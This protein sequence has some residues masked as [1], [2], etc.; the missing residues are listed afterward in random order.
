ML[1]TGDCRLILSELAKQGGKPALLRR[2]TTA[3]RFGDSY[4]TMGRLRDMLF[5]DGL[6][7]PFSATVSYDGGCGF[8]LYSTFS[9]NSKG[10]CDGCLHGA[11]ITKALWYLEFLFRIYVER[12]NLFK[13]SA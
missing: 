7:A 1:H 10:F 8:I 3:R 4:R 2:R 11:T 12:S 9:H 5:S 13:V 6:T